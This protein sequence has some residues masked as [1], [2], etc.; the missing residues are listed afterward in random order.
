MLFAK[1][2]KSWPSDFKGVQ[3][4]KCLQMDG[5]TA[6]RQNVKQCQVKAKPK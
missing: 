2:G 3:S 1:F 4:V 5:Q 6:D